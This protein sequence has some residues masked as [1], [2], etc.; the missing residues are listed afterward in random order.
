MAAR[1]KSSKASK[2]NVTASK[3][4]SKAA[5][6]KTR[7]KMSTPGGKAS[8]AGAKM[9]RPVG[10]SSRSSAKSSKPAVKSSKSGAKSSTRKSTRSSATPDSVRTKIHGFAAKAL[11]DGPSALRDL[12][13]VTRAVIADAAKGLNASVPQSNRNVLRQVVDS[14]AEAAVVTTHSVRNAFNDSTAR[15]AEFVRKDAARTMS[16]LRS[17]EANFIG[18]LEHAQKSLSGAAKDELDAIVK[19]AKRAGTRVGPAAQSALKAAD[20]RLAELGVETARAS[21][22]V[23]RRTI[24]GMLDG[25][26]GILQALGEAVSGRP[27]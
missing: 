24:G 26:S 20:G 13:E 9:A 22:R 19:H 5:P 18:A 1:K 8:K 27:R 4:S 11:R 14:M 2:A 17:L 23:T 6:A 10:K 21:A 12:P 7:A 25:A 15:G 3:S 16:D